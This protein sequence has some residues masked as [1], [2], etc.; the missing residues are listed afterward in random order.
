VRYDCL[1]EPTR[2][3]S[4]RIALATTSNVAPVSTMIAN[5]TL[6]CPARVNAKKSAFSPKAKV[7]LKRMIGYDYTPWKGRSCRRSLAVHAC[8]DSG[9]YPAICRPGTMQNHQSHRT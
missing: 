3:R 6:K 5:H 8:T 7:M 2:A 1:I 9:P 4:K